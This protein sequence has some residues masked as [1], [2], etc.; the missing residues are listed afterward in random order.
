MCTKKEFLKTV[1]N[2]CGSRKHKIKNSYGVN[3]AFKYY[4]KTRPKNTKR[5]LNESDYFAII[6]TFNKHLIDILLEGKTVVLPENMGALEVRKYKTSV[7]LTD[8]G[9]KTNHPIDWDKTLDLWYENPECFV[10]KMLIHTENPEVFR[11]LYIK[12]KAKY[13][14]KT[15]YNFSVNRELKKL[16]KLNIQNNELDAYLIK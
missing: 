13:N 4:R 2:V 10:N 3:D 6:R 15:F 7:T 5:V 12:S 1:K 14:N 16:L 11:L 9:I 8:T